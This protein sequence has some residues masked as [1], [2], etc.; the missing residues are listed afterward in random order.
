[1]MLTIP[2]KLPDTREPAYVVG[3]SIRDLLL[4][5]SPEDYDIVVHGN[6]EK[7][8]RKLAAIHH[9]RAI[10]L[11]QDEKRIFRVKGRDT[12]YDVSQIKGDAIEADLMQRDFTVNALAYDTRSG[13]IIDVSHGRRD[14][15][16]GQIRMVTTAIF[17]R[18]PIRLLRAYRVAVQLG[19]CIEAH[20][21]DTIRKK[22][23]LIQLAAA[24]RIRD[25]WFR[26]LRQSSISACLA[27]MNGT[28]LLTAVFPELNHLADLKQNRYHE[29]DALSHTIKTV[30]H[31]ESLFDGPEK[32][33]PQSAGTLNQVLS[34]QRRVVLKCA[35][36]LHDVGKP[37]A[38]SM[39][40]KGMRHHYGHEKI[41]A[42][43]VEN[44]GRKFRFSNQERTA[45]ALI[46]RQHLRPLFLFN[47]A[48]GTMPK[49][50]LMARFFLACGDLVP[51]IVLHAVADSR[52]KKADADRHHRQFAAFADSLLHE[53]FSAFIVNNEAPR[54]ISGHDLIQAFKLDPSPLFS[55]ILKQVEEARIAGE[56]NSK[57]DAL[58]LVG[59]MLD[60]LN[61][62]QTTTH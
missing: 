13:N 47:Q 48:N 62:A 26:I 52:A 54:L 30:E 18:D 3:G 25:E 36:V 50:R 33:L 14:L 34:P 51:D 31:L 2:C 44:M 55:N 32:I 28:G 10:A 42:R 4:K 12:L 16:A 7:Y 6:P 20:T 61:L 41:G 9:A 37:A 56:V 39:D 8:A 40:D 58:K 35:A 49:Q 57:A 24:E 15:D 38:A 11:G 21:L 53:Y 27:D 43:M 5:R 45:I 22:S 23:L 19:F 17:D 29:F 1:M 46:V 60:K 59:C